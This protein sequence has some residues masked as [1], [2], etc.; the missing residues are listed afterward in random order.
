MK[1]IRRFLSLSDRYDLLRLNVEAKADELVF[2]VRLSDFDMG[3]MRVIRHK[4]QETGFIMVDE[5]LRLRKAGF[6]TSYP[7]P[8]RRMAVSLMVASST[9]TEGVLA[10]GTMTPTLQTFPSQP[11]LSLGFYPS[12]TW[13]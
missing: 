2:R 1:I 6:N 8:L 13:V 3:E 4:Q 7:S 10:Q 12:V 9:A 5:L 11:S